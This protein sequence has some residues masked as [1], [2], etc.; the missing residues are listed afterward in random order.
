MSMSVMTNKQSQQKTAR[1][2]TQIDVF[3]IKIQNELKSFE[4]K[5]KLNDTFEWCATFMLTIYGLSVKN[6]ASTPIITQSTRKKI[7]HSIEFDRKM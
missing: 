5:L 7:S 1:R 4:M 3:H 2:K 6:Y